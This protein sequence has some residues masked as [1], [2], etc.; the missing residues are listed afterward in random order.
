MPSTLFPEL[1]TTTA[2]G[3]STAPDSSGARTCSSPHGGSAGRGLARD[4]PSK[5]RALTRDTRHCAD[6]S[7]SW[8]D[9]CATPYHGDETI[10]L[11]GAARVATRVATRVAARGT[12]GVTPWADDAR[13]GFV[14]ALRRDLRDRVRPGEHVAFGTA[15]DPYPPQESE[16]RI[17]SRALS[18]LLDADGLRLSI[19]TRSALVARDAR[20]LAHLGERH[21]VHV[22]IAL[23]TPDARLARILEP[24]VP[25]PEERLAALRALREHDVEAGIV[26]MPLLPGVS[27]TDQDLDA[28]LGAA[29]AAGARWVG[30]RVVVLREPSRSEFLRVLRR[31]YP[32]VA[33]RYAWWTSSRNSA[34]GGRSRSGRGNTRRAN[35]HYGQLPPDVCHEALARVRSLA[36][37]HGLPA[38]PDL[39]LPSPRAAPRRQATF[40]FAGDTW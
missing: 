30:A 17:T 16:E 25:A 27:D 38:T 24:R 11:A 29:A 1:T 21:A 4:R 7:G 28:L 6:E 19:T 34:R 9:W 13:D 18:V 14:A 2:S 5:A 33:A 10:A 39:R 12:D 8:C 3:A 36:A 31:S 22:N 35:A 23:A 26:L 20:L 32:R 37:A 40:S 15:V